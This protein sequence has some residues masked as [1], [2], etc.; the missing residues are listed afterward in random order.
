M[1]LAWAATFL[2]PDRMG[3]LTGPF[4]ADGY[5]RLAIDGYLDRR[6]STREPG[7]PPY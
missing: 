7:R 3:C 6:S 4:P 2:G 5:L 1:I